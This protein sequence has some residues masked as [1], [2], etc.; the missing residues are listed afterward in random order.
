MLEAITRGSDK[1][2][3][4]RAFIPLFSSK[5]SILISSGCKLE[6]FYHCCPNYEVVEDCANLPLHLIGV[7]CFITLASCAG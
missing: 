1:G 2:D 3:V 6:K 4:K 5:S 7:V